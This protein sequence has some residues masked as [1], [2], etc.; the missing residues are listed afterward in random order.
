[1]CLFCGAAQRCM[2]CKQQVPEPLLLCER[3]VGVF[4]QL[5]MCDASM[6]ASRRNFMCMRG[7]RGCVL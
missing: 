5:H 7:W 1:M 6:A 4:V 2:V 3:L